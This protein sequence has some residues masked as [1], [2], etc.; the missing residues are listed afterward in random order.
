LL[1]HVRDLTANGFVVSNT[2]NLV[3]GKTEKLKTTVTNAY[4]ALEEEDYQT[5]VTEETERG[6]NKLLF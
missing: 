3:N 4:A 2:L 1:H 6:N 5:T